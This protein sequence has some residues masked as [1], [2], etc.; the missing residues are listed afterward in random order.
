MIWIWFENRA[1]SQIAQGG[2]PPEFA[3]LGRDCGLATNYHGV[4]HPSLPNYLAAATGRSPGP[5]GDCQPVACPQSGQTLFAQLGASR[6]AAYDESMPVSCD[7]HTAG[8]YA[9]RHNPAVYFANI[10]TACLADDVNL[11]RLPAVL[12]AGKLPA[13][14]WITP[15][16]CSDMHNCSAA[17]G[18]AWLARWLP[19]LVAAPQY[20]SGSTVIFITWDESSGASPTNRVPLFVVAPSVPAGSR[21]TAFANHFALLHT[22][23]ALLGLPALGSAARALVLSAG[24]GL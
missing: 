22:T 7:R 16:L 20:Q 9:P 19:R 1:F 3:R 13:F 10:R 2:G 17:T 23:E 14:S 4:T 15:N 6:W 8:D 5:I 21:V 18:A 12:A 11:D 24:F